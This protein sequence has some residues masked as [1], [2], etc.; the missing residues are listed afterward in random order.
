MWRQLIAA[1]SRTAVRVPA[2]TAVLPRAG[3]A[4]AWVDP[5]SGAAANCNTVQKVSPYAVQA[6]H[7]S[8]AI[9]AGTSVAVA[10]VGL[11]YAFEKYVAWRDDPHRATYAMRRHYRGPFED[12]M[13]KSE[14]AR[15]LGVRESSAQDVILKAHRKLM[16]ANH[17]DRGGSTFLAG[18]VNEAKDVLTGG[19]TA[20]R[21]R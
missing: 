7:S 18:K 12:D 9:V 5:R 19:G 15:I 1:S 10:S 13:T 4:A 2:S 6:A 20:Q 11:K 16:I 14:A 8:A 21:G 17:P 3:V